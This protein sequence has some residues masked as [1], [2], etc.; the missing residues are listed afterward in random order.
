[1][2]LDRTL[3][4]HAYEWHIEPIIWGSSPDSAL[5]QAGAI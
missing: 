4:V 5:I 3:M 2:I 1:M